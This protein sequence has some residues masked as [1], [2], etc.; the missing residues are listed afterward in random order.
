[1]ISPLIKWN[2]EANFLVP[3]FDTFSYYERRKI[4]INLNDKNFEFVKGHV[5]D[6]RVLFPAAGWICLVWETFGLMNGIYHEELPVIFD[7]IKLLRATS[8]KNNQDVFV[9]I[10]IQRGT[11]RFEIVEGASAIA[12]GFIKIAQ[13]VGMTEISIPTDSVEGVVVINEE[14]FFQEMRTRG[15][16]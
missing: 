12:N 7:D 10:N 8:L 16:V 13:N 2:H 3:W 11:G 9:T 15:E 6:G 5:I 4:A 14:E 1:M